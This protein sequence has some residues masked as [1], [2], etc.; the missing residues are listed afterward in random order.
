MEDGGGRG[1]LVFTGVI[2]K[3][4]IAGEIVDGIVDGIAAGIVDGIVDGIVEDIADGITGGIVESILDD[5]VDG[6]VDC[7]TGV[8]RGADAEGRKSVCEGKTPFAF[9]GRSPELVT[10]AFLGCIL[11]DGVGKDRGVDVAKGI[12]LGVGIDVGIGAGEESGT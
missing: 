6:I 8:G 12:D 10:A 7:C 9:E 3:G 1:V 2:I 11:D 4:A 5:I